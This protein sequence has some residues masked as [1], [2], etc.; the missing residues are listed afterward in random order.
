MKSKKTLPWIWWRGLIFIFFIYSGFY[1]IFVERHLLMEDEDQIYRHLIRIITT[2]AVYIIGSIHLKFI[3]IVWMKQLWHFI[4]ISLFSTLLIFG[5][6][7]W[8]SPYFTENL[9]YWG[10]VF[11]EILISPTLYCSMAILNKIYNN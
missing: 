8:F 6:I 4:H 11:Q 5:L 2:L 9:S 3:Q 7:K 1:L 10:L